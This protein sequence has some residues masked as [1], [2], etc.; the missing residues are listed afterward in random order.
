MSELGE[1]L[2]N[3]REEKNLSLEELQATTKIQKRYLQAIE[4]GDYD[5][6][7][8]QFYAR[9]FIKNY[10]EALGLD[11]DRIFDEYSGEIPVTNHQWPESPPLSSSR[12]LRRE[13]GGSKLPAL[14]PKL[15]AVAIVI[16]IMLVI[17]FV[18]F[19]FAPDSGQE[20]G[21]DKGTSVGLNENTDINQKDKHADQGE[22]KP[23]KEKSSSKHE[24][25]QQKSTSSQK[26]KKTGSEG[27]VV[28][29]TLKNAKA[30]K[31]KLAIKDS[32][33]WIEVRRS[34][35]EGKAYEYTTVEAP[36][37]ITHDLSKNK[38]VYV[39]IGSTPNVKMSINGKKFNYPD[40]KTTQ[41][42]LITYEAPK[43]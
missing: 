18:F 3:T 2:K 9:A 39:T 15:L 29:Y 42:F 21:S 4:K 5:Q 1:T 17:Y 40:D 8:G 26:L 6:L 23:S 7:P 25:K 24:K 30:F 33:S 27:N 12:G 19:H 43:D 28:H 11:S 31:L 32:R 22:D 13:P 14:L 38:K 16:G 37:T 41:R 35:K 36:K 10:A 20:G 34:G